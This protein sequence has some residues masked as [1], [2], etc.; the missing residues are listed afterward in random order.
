MDV[1]CKTL[2]N[3]FNL[4]IVE[5]FKLKM[6]VKLIVLC[7]KYSYFMDSFLQNIEK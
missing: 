5:I 7:V 1:F 3:Y 2:K 6:K 4:L